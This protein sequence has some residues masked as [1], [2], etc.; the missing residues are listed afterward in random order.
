MEIHKYIMKCSVIQ[1]KGVILKAKIYY[2]LS[3]IYVIK[4]FQL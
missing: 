4:C 1:H 2:H 3:H